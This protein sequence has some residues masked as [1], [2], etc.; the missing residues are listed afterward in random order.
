MLDVFLKVT[1]L[2]VVLKVWLVGDHLIVGV[3]PDRADGWI[4]EIVKRGDGSVPLGMGA[5]VVVDEPA[6]AV[7]LYPSV[8]G[9]GV[10]RARIRLS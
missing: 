9:E 7:E 1:I 10:P 2:Q 3:H 8:R 5:N 6:V 4:P